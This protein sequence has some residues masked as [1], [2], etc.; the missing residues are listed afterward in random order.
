MFTIILPTYNEYQNIEKLI[1]TLLKLFR[2][3]KLN[4]NILIIDDNSHDGTGILAERFSKI[5]KSVKVIHR[6]KKSGIGSAYI[7]GFKQSL[8]SD[9]VFEMDSDFSHNPKY[10]IRFLDAIRDADVVTGSRYIPGGSIHN[11]SISRKAISFFGNLSAKLFLRLPV[12][13]C[14]TGYRAIR[15]KCLRRIDMDKIDVQGYAFQVKLLLELRQAGAKIIEIP[16]TF[17]ERR[18]G[19][20][21]LGIKDIL[22]FILMI[23]EARLNI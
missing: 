3:Y 23:L 12:M 1:P 14:T 6:P 20:S 16:I 4:G 10:I 2:K 13:D 7:K 21:K 9:I 17:E 22:E 11:W 15:T 18:F 19:S 5:Y 8:D